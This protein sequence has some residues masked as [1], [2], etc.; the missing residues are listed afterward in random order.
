MISVKSIAFGLLL[1]LAQHTM[2]PGAQAE[3]QQKSVATLESAFH[4]LV[5]LTPK[6]CHAFYDRSAGNEANNL[7][8][9][10]VVEL[11]NRTD[12]VVALRVPSVECEL[13]DARLPARVDL[14]AES[15]T[16]MDQ[17]VY[18]EPHQT[19]SISIAADAHIANAPGDTPVTV[20]LTFVGRSSQTP[21]TTPN[22]QTNIV[23]NA[24]AYQITAGPPNELQQS[25]SPPAGLVGVKAVNSSI[26]VARSQTSAANSFIAKT[27]LDV[28][29]LQEAPI[30]VRLLNAGLRSNTKTESVP[31]G[32]FIIEDQEKPVGQQI[33]LNEHQTKR[34]TVISRGDFP[35]TD[36]AGSLFCIDFQVNAFIDLLPVTANSKLIDA[37]PPAK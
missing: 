2:P 37:I 29:N 27:E 36:S 9:L 32:L 28:Q 33:F 3:G 15:K 23:L 19:L 10:T 34:I 12:E 20:S 1:L 13:G 35:F 16:I 14:G 24:P 17:T 4:N 18:L 26:W 30:S 5:T 8:V 25:P 22:P 11:S 31:V 21:R 6:G 7:F